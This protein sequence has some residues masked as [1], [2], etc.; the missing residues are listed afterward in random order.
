VANS[1][2]GGFPSFS[3]SILP[4]LYAFHLSPQL[5]HLVRAERGGKGSGQDATRLCRLSVNLVSPQES[6][7][8]ALCFGHELQNFSHLTPL[9]QSFRDNVRHTNKSSTTN[10][11]SAPSLDHIVIGQGKR[12]S[13]RQLGYFYP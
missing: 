10:R 11:D 2:V 13:L 6:E 1:R 8:A 5:I 3:L 9:E 7:S 4:I 12:I